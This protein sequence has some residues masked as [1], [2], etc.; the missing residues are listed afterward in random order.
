LLSLLTKIMPCVNTSRSK[1]GVTCLHKNY[2]I[3]QVRELKAMN[4]SVNKTTAGI[5]TL[6]GVLLATPAGQA[7]DVYGP[8]A[9]AGIPGESPCFAVFHEHRNGQGISLERQGPEAIP[10]I[11]DMHYSDGGTLNRRVMSVT[12]GPGAKLMLYDASRFRV[13]MFEVGPDSQVNLARPVMDSYELRCKAQHAPQP[14]LPPRGY[15]R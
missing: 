15:K 11:R 6:L 8:G 12:T 10:R 1:L 14:Y 9:G 13:P 4:L 3:K 5:F 2:E 7:A